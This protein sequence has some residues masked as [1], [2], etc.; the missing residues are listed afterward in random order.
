MRLF[1]V[2]IIGVAV[3]GVAVRAQP[4]EYS[5]AG[6]ADAASS[7][8]ARLSPNS[9]GTLY[10]NHLA[11]ATNADVFVLIGRRV[12]PVTYAS[13]HQVNFIVPG[14]LASGRPYSFSLSRNGLSGPEF[15]VDIVPESPEFF[16]W[17]TGM[18]LAARPDGT[19]IVPG[20]PARPGEI[21]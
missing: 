14:D 16:A 4:P 3:W 15:M 12:V 20:S 21:A 9:R 17:P 10:G 18:V 11:A 19:L 6:L 5:L 13:L 8:P 7:V 1:A 2:L